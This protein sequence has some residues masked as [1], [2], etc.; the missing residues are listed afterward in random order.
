MAKAAGTLWTTKGAVMA[1][2]EIPEGLPEKEMAEIKA[3]GLI[4][5]DAE[6]AP[7]SEPVAKLKMAKA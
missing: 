5:V 6:L 7:A 2:D 4:A 1:G 3:S